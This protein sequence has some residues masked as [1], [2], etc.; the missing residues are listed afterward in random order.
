MS[1]HTQTHAS[2]VMCAADLRKQQQQQ[3]QQ[4]KQQQQHTHTFVS[5]RLD[6]RVKNKYLGP[7]A[8]AQL[9]NIVGGSNSC[10][11]WTS[12]SSANARQPSSA[13]VVIVVAVAGAAKLVRRRGDAHFA[14]NSEHFVT[15]QR[16]DQRGR[17]LMTMDILY[18]VCG[19]KTNSR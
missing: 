17:Q 15:S 11:S 6:G 8:A 19:N 2:T 13:V 14:H 18:G 10:C 16:F 9:R 4:Q 3:Q 7:F 1:T 12:L 5:T